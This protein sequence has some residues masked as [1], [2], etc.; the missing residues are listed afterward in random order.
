MDS[1]AIYRMLKTSYPSLDNKIANFMAQNVWS[2]VRKWHKAELKKAKDEVRE[3]TVDRRALTDE[4]RAEELTKFLDAKLLDGSMTAAELAQF[5]DIYG[6]KAKE[7]D[8]SINVVE[9]KDV[10]PEYADVIATTAELV[11]EKIRKANEN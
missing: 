3:S 1:Q 5:K 6:L 9:F 7:R 2:D 10:Y 4:E 8:V 11:D